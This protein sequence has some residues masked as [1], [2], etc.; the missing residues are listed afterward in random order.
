MANKRNGQMNQREQNG[1]QV[2][3]EAQCLIVS[4]DQCVK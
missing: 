1:S 4:Q 3:Q 2:V